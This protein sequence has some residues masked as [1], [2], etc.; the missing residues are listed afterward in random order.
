MSTKSA[1][2]EGFLFLDCHVW[3]ID[4]LAAVFREEK[5]SL[6]IYAQEKNLID[7]IYSR[8]KPPPEYIFENKTSSTIYA[9]K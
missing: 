6:T 5:T 1:G 2:L 4:F 3:N 9:R 7:N 8:E